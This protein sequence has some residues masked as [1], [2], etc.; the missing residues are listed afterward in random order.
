MRPKKTG[1]FVVHAC[2]LDILHV[3]ALIHVSEIGDPVVLDI[4][5]DVVNSIL[6][7]VTMNP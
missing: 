7:P 6:R 5:V 4:T 2:L 3:G 1:C